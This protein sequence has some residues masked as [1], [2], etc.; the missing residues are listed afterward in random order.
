MPN[1]HAAGFTT[2]HYQHFERD[3]IFSMPAKTRSGASFRG[4]PDSSPKASSTEIGVSN[5]K[6]LRQRNHPAG[7]GT[8]SPGAAEKMEDVESARER[9]SHD[10]ETGGLTEGSS[11]KAWR[12]RSQWIAYA[13]ASG[14]CAAFNGVFAKLCVL[15]LTV[16]RFS[17]RTDLLPG[18]PMTS[19]R[20]WPRPS[21]TCSI[22]LPKL[23]S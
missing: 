9:G 12:A 15:P 4:H 14:V 22:S 16:P 8:P 5:A 23:R 20:R 18:Q 11:P 19:P 7:H 2:I 21:R 3:T 1:Q 10:D 17:S 6:G 13:V